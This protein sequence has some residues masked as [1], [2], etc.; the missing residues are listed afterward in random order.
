MLSIPKVSDVLWRPWYLW[1]VTVIG[2][3]VCSGCRKKNQD[4][5]LPTIRI[6][7]PSLGSF[8]YYGDDIPIEAFVD[9]ETQLKS[10]EV[11]IT[12]NQG[13]R[14]LQTET[15]SPTS[16]TFEIS[17][18]IRHNDLYLSSGTYYVRVR[19]SDGENEQFAFREI[20]LTEA[21]RRVENLFVIRDTGGSSYVDSLS[22]TT[23]TPCLQFPHQ[24]FKG[25]INARMNQLV[26]CSTHPGD[27]I[28]LSYPWFDILNTNFPPSN[29]VITAFYQDL[30]NNC[31]YWGTISGVVWKTDLQ[32]TRLFSS[33][34]SGRITAIGTSSDYVVVSS[35]NV[36]QQFVSAIRADNGIIETTLTIGWQVKGIIHITS[37]PDRILLIGN[38]ANTSY[39]AW[40]NLNTSA[41]NEVYNFY[42]TSPVTSVCDAAGNDFYVIHSNGIARYVNSMS[43]YT[44]G[45]FPNAEKLIYDEVGNSVWAIAPNSL[46]Q[47][48]AVAQN[49]IQSLTVTGIQDF[50]IK[51]NK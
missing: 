41:I 48:D 31:F 23:L 3:I 6:E 1:L 29:D 4:E 12:D 8:Y 20:Q 26:M 32:G 51:Y 42:D 39:F 14:F 49:T 5:T 40:L 50:W 7:T 2:L 47:L 36:N 22:G 16:N 38:Q 45:N 11:A 35:E 13:N 15:Y 24:Y 34:S 33:T 17:L 30:Q 27:L 25:G 21:P 18:S 46:V 9:D 43:S 28:S 19:A 44:L 37:E 10:I